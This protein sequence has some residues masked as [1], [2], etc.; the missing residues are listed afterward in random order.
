MSDSVNEP[1]QLVP[2]GKSTPTAIIQ[3]LDARRREAA[4]AGEEFVLA[5][6][7][8]TRGKSGNWRTSEVWSAGPT[9]ILFYMA[10]ALRDCFKP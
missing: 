3:Q 9:E 1:A 6:T 8:A 2:W 10:H 4:T 5:V 7:F